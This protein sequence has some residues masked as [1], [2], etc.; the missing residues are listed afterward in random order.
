MSRVLNT[1]YMIAGYLNGEGAPRY[2]EMHN[3]T[4]DTWTYWSSFGGKEF[5]T[6][7]AASAAI[8]QSGPDMWYGVKRVEL[9]KVQTIAEVVNIDFNSKLESSC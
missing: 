2:W 7:E 4:D 5:I 3:D 1:C 8:D 6:A 9:L